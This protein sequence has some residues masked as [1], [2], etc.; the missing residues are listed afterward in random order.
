MK[1]YM[2]EAA[3]ELPSVAGVVDRST[4]DLEV[5]LDDGGT[6]R[7]LVVRRPLGGPS[8]GLAERVGALMGEK[9]RALRGFRVLSLAERWYPSIGGIE[10]KLRHRGED[11]EMLYQHQ[12]HAALEWEERV[13]WL[14]F[15]GEMPIEAAEVCDRWMTSVLEGLVIRDG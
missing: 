8:S 1:V 6:L 10:V 13:T 11:G 15:H 7:F 5:T 3:L 2:N 4:H 12:L 14:A 9:S